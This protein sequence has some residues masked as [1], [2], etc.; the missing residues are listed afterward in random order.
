VQ[1]RKVSVAAARDAYGVVLDGDGASVD[2]DATKRRRD[3][4]RTARGAT[5]WL[6]DRGGDGRE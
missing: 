5:G 2:H 6:F 1:D 4:M 3:A